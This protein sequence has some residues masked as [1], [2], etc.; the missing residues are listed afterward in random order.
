M[1]VHALTYCVRW[2]TYI[3]KNEEAVR[4]CDANTMVFTRLPMSGAIWKTW[5]PW[6]ST[7]ASP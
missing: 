2:Y 4:V 7:L 1:R 3:T 6:A 5:T